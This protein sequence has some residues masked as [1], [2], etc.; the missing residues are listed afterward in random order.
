MG[1]NNFLKSSNDKLKIIKNGSGQNSL[2]RSIAFFGFLF[3]SIA[4]C[5][6]ALK[7]KITA[8]MFLTYPLGLVILYVP[9]LAIT[10]LK[11]WKGQ[12]IE[13]GQG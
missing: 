11:I 12:N 9:A 4:F 13:G 5:L 6:A 2:K 1:I 3:M 10:L 8:E 7:G